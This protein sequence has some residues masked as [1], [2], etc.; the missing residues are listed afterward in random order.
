MKRIPFGSIVIFIASA[1]LETEI[2]ETNIGATN[3]GKYIVSP[4]QA[5]LNT[6]FSAKTNINS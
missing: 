3:V 1:C 4:Q 5:K 6:Q 2:N